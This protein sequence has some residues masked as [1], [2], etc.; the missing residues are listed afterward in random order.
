MLFGAAFVCE[1][2]LEF[3]CG[4]GIHWEVNRCNL[5]VRDLRRLREKCRAGRAD[6]RLGRGLDVKQ[7]AKCLV[8]HFHRAIGAF[9]HAGVRDI[10][11]HIQQMRS[12][13][14]GGSLSGLF[15]REVTQ[16]PHDSCG[17][18]TLAPAGRQL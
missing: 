14:I 3:V 18:A 5:L 10:L 13:H 1:R 9:N 11:D 15:Y 7:F 4:D 16:P 2:K 6:E 17:L 8:N 12:L